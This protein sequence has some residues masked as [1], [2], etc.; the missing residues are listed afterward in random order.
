MSFRF[1]RR[2]RVAPPACAVASADRPDYEHVAAR[3]DVA[4]ASKQGRDST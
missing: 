1:W 3:L 4:V 2:L